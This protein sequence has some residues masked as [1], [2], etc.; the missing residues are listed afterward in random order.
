MNW[1]ATVDGEVVEEARTKADLVWMLQANHDDIRERTIERVK[2]GYY[3]YV[4][5]RGNSTY[6][7]MRGEG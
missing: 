4:S 1:I 3:I 5:P 6:H 7:I 2:A